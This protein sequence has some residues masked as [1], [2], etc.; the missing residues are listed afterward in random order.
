V[1]LERVN[2]QRSNLIEAKGRGK[3]RDGMEGGVCGEITGRGYHL[4]CK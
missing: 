2:G 3:R 4:K 1:N